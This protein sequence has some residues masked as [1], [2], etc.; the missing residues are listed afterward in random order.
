MISSNRSVPSII[1]IQSRVILHWDV[2]IWIKFILY[3]IH[4]FLWSASNLFAKLWIVFIYSHLCRFALAWSQILYIIV[5]CMI[6]KSALFGFDFNLWLRWNF[7]FLRFAFLF[8]CLVFFIEKCEVVWILLFLLWL[9]RFLV[10]FLALMIDAGNYTAEAIVDILLVFR[11]IFFVITYAFM[12]NVS[13]K[14][15]V[16]LASTW[17]FMTRVSRSVLMANSVL[18]SNSSCCR[19]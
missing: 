11:R 7:L 1:L 19:C 8:I 17:D 18:V 15:T 12:A 3:C 9:F 5:I 6:I 14:N 4:V 13:S 10:F 16:M 2:I